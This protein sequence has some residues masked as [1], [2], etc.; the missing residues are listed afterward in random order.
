MTL[1]C[2]WLILISNEKKGI[3]IWCLL[4][5]K[6]QLPKS[7]KPLVFKFIIVHLMLIDL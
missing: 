3:E 2:L 4:Q 6:N 7:K 5:T 1:T